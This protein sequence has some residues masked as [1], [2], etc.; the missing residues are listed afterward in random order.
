M[1]FIIAE[2]SRYII[3]MLFAVYTFYG[4]RVFMKRTTE[5]KERV[6]RAQRTLIFLMHLLCSAILL[7]ENKSMQYVLLYL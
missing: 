5:G 6:F 4:F 7:M 1:E 3:I 2:L